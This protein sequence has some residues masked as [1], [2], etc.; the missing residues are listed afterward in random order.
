[1]LLQGR[2]AIG[3]ALSLHDLLDAD[4]QVMGLVVGLSACLRRRQCVRY[5][6]RIHR[7]RELLWQAPAFC[8]VV[9]F[10]G[11]TRRLWHDLRNLHGFAVL[12]FGTWRKLLFIPGMGRQANFS[13]VAVVVAQFVE[14]ADRLQTASVIIGRLGNIRA[15]LREHSS[16]SSILITRA[17]AQSKMASLSSSGPTVL[18][19]VRLP[20]L[21]VG[22]AQDISR[23]L[24]AIQSPS[25]GLGSSAAGARRTRGCSCHIRRRHR[26]CWRTWPRSASKRGDLAGQDLLAHLAVYAQENHIAF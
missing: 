12:A 7:R 10:E 3:L 19:H 15:C 24:L 23:V 14:F 13:K 22:V 4:S 18:L 8:V 11:A 9:D 20:E 17:V 26:T 16:L 5:R 1:M 21:G 25:H 2:A 6:I